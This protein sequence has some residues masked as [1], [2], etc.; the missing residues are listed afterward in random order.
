MFEDA[1][2]L[3]A[4]GVIDSRAFRAALVQ[5]GDAPAPQL[6]AVYFTATL[7]QWLRL[8]RL[9][10]LRLVAPVDEKRG[11]LPGELCGERAP[12]AVGGAGDEDRLLVLVFHRQRFQSRR[13][14]PSYALVGKRCRRKR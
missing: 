12:Q 9:P 13:W 11:A 3:D 1:G 5:V 6:G 7:E 14:W 8:D 2:M 10:A 4:L